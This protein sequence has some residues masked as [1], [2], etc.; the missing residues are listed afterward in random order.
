[1]RYDSKMSLVLTIRVV[2]V[3]KPEKVSRNSFLSGIHREV[4]E[5][6]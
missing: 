5:A 2:Q 4:T 6:E 3:Y 1:M